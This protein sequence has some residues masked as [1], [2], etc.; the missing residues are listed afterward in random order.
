MKILLN[1]MVF[2]EIEL[3]INDNMCILIFPITFFI[4][5]ISIF[6]N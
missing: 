5:I 3:N 1:N 2:M 4:Y 6:I